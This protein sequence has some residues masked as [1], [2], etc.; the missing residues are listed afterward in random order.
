MYLSLKNNLGAKYTVP[1]TETSDKSSE[2]TKSNEAEFA[3]VDDGRKI[4]IFIAIAA[5]LALVVIIAI[6]VAVV[7]SG[8]QGQTVSIVAV[9]VYIHGHGKIDVSRVFRIHFY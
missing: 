9:I 8:G 6:V 7:L 5:I 2:E 4:K 3:K 1:Q